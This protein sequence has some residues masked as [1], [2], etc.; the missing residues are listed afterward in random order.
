[1]KVGCSI[2]GRGLGHSFGKLLAFFATETLCQI[3]LYGFQIS[4]P[5]GQVLHIIYP[6]L[7]LAQASKGKSYVTDDT[8]Q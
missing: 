8:H 6:H 2:R 5:M 3:L 1:M 4:W 7:V